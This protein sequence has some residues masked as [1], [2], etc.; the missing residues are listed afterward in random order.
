[1]KMLV[2]AAEPEPD[3]PINSTFQITYRYPCP[4]IIPITTGT[5]IGWWPPSTTT[6]TLAWPDE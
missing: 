5:A 1:V 6:E 4:T 3:P 2:G